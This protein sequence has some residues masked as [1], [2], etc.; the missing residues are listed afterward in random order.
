MNNF[1]ELSN[2]EL[3]TIDG[4]WN[5][6]LVLGGAALVIECIAIAATAPASLP[7]LA[8]GALCAASA[9]GGSAIGYGATH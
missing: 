4:G 9:L 2:N 8:A 6:E 7:I 5:W 3:F 1:I